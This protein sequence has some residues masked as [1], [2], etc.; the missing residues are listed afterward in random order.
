MENKNNYDHMLFYFAYKSFINTADEII[1]EHGMNRQH[2][3]F[4]F[5]IDQMPGI[6]LKQLLETLEISKQASHASLKML[7][8]KGLIQYRD[9]E[10][11]RRVKHLYPTQEGTSLVSILN[12][13]QNDLL[14]ETFDTAGSDWHDVMEHLAQKKAGFKNVKSI[15]SDK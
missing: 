15:R 5:F 9:S 4:L 7:Q 10:H 2:H 12:Q 8:E 13:A 3:R 11:D 1:Q 6:T 14:Q